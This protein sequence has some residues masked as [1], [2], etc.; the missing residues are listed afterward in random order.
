MCVYVVQYFVNVF[1]CTVTILPLL[2]CISGLLLLYVLQY[3]I[4]VRFNEYNCRVLTSLSVR[5]LEL[6]KGKKDV[7]LVKVRYNYQ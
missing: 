6:T 5:H 4:S 2:F 3:Q 7:Q 1:H